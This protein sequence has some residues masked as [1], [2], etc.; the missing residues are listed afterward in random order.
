MA[1]LLPALRPF[2]RALDLIDRPGGHKT[3]HGEVPVVGG[4]GMFVGLFI[5]VFGSGQRGQIGVSV[6]AISG[7]M[8]FLGALDDRFNLSPRVRLCCHLAAAV[9]LVYGTGAVVTDLGDLLGTGVVRLGW[10]ALPFTVVSLVALVNAFNMLDGLDGLAGSTAL[11][12]FLGLGGVASAQGQGVA[13]LICGSMVGA[14]AAFLLYN[15]PLH[16]N[17]AVRTFMG[18]AGSTL[19]GFLFA[20][21]ALLVV[22]PSGHDVP[23][24][25]ILWLIPIPIFELFASTARRV[26]KG[27]SPAQADNGHFHHVLLRAGFSVR[28]ICAV[29]VLFSACSAYA[30]WRAYQAAVSEALLCGGFCVLFGLWLLF[31]ANARLLVLRLP[32]ALR[33]G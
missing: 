20:S 29:Y 11:V 4:L 9:A 28:L 12:G 6:L 24:V 17:H 8:V 27:L 2:A 13:L 25:L 14:I 15:M 16:F 19:L 22:Q 31:V 30:G 21:V 26:L 10:L 32:L 18:D 23:P 1:A 7:L 3:H 5:A 33:R